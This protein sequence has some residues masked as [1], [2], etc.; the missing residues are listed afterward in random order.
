MLSQRKQT[1]VSISCGCDQWCRVRKKKKLV[2]HGDCS[3]TQDISCGRNWSKVREETILENICERSHPTEAK[4]PE[5]EKK[6]VSPEEKIKGK[7][8]PRYQ[9]VWSSSRWKGVRA[10]TLWCPVDISR[11]LHRPRRRWT[12][13]GSLRMQSH[14]GCNMLESLTTC[15]NFLL[16][17]IKVTPGYHHWKVDLSA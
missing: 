10:Q 12:Q 9:T 6:V 3:D 5:T 15:S 16:G 4:V 14:V 2:W 1:S 17:L 13:K 7:Q 11:Y 8:A